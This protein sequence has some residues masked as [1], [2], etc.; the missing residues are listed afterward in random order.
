[1]IS[2]VDV[3][4]FDIYDMNLIVRHLSNDNAALKLIDSR[5]NWS[6]SPNKQQT[7]RL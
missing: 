2:D 4:E 7:V 1:M 6:I 5:N 3:D